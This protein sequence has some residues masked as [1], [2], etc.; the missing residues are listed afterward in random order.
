MFIHQA[1]FPAGAAE[2]VQ[3]SVEQW[4]SQALLLASGGNFKMLSDLRPGLCLPDPALPDIRHHE[5][6][7]AQAHAQRHRQRHQHGR[8]HLPQV[9]GLPFLLETEVFREGQALKGSGRG[10]GGL[11]RG[12]RGPKKPSNP[13][14]MERYVTTLISHDD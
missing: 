8:T 9:E 4:S 2:P 13:L 5:R 11:K 3:R 10:L 12:L 14:T 7:L 6:S 1:F